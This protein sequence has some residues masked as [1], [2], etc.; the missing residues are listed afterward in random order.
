LTPVPQEGL[1]REAGGAPAPL[2]PGGGRRTGPE[3]PAR[4]PWSARRGCVTVTCARPAA[5]GLGTGT[6][7]GPA[8]MGVRVDRARRPGRVVCTGAA[9]AAGPDIRAVPRPAVTLLRRQGPGVG[10]AA[11]FGVGLAAAPE[12]AEC[13]RRSGMP[14]N[15]NRDRD[16]SIRACHNVVSAPC[17]AGVGER[18]LPGP[19]R[20]GTRGASLA[21]SGE[22]GR[23]SGGPAERRRQTAASERRADGGAITVI[24]S[25]LVA[26]EG[27]WRVEECGGCCSCSSVVADLN[28]RSV[29][30]GGP[31]GKDSDGPRSRRDS[32]AVVTP[33]SYWKRPGRW[34]AATASRQ[35]ADSEPD[36]ETQALAQWRA[37]IPARFRV[38][39]L[40]PGGSAASRRQ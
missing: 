25:P 27:V 16:E 20:V 39:R 28:L 29:G 32:D 18:G 40:G 30:R 21:R 26:Y 37:V 9:A 33:V 23:R 15:L 3:G 10:P 17:I 31:T 24:R 8:T 14:T 38:S 6:P 22:R 5:G 19:A 1:R 36:S 35:Q 11:G 4:G 34:Q 7:A 13:T 2:T 12:G